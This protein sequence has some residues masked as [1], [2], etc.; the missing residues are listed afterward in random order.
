MSPMP[1]RRD[2][3]PP[4]VLPVPMRRPMAILAGLAGI[5]VTVLAVHYAG[6]ATAGPLDQR[7]RAGVW[8]L[9][10]RARPGALVLDLFGEPVVAALLVAALA[11]L[12]LA[13]R[14]RALAVVALVG[15]ALTGVATTTLKP[16]VG[17]TIHGGH[18]AYPSGHTATVTALA[19]VGML[20]VA[21]LVRSGRAVGLLLVLGGAGAAGA[22]MAVAQIVL[23]AHYPT[24][25]VGGFAVALAVVPATAL[26]VDRFAARWRWLRSP[27]D[28]SR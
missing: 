21:S 2:P 4:P 5:V 24:D 9:F 22:V 8:N 11:A 3:P 18:L 26:L 17:R 6:T 13:L 28:A 19:L 12:C 25:T 15:P 23:D 27:T 1:E 16:V 20:L 7:L 14:R 10:G